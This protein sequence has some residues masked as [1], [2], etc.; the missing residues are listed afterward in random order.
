MNW[1]REEQAMRIKFED[2]I[3]H[4]DEF[5]EQINAFLDLKKENHLFPKRNFDP[6]I[7]IKNTCLWKRYPVPQSVLEKIERE[8]PE[9]CYSFERS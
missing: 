7:S 3:Y 6:A 5:A 4:Y 9:F 1:Q 2:A 8:L